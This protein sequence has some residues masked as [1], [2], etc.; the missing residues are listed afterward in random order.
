MTLSFPTPIDTPAASS[1]PRI[2]AQFLQ[3][4]SQERTA[5][6]QLT[7][8]QGAVQLKE[9]TAGPEKIMQAKL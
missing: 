7:G 1:I 9:H 2:G 6:I 5:N 4:R 3:P 8:R